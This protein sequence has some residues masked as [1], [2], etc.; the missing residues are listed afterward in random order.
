MSEHG[1][2]DG[3]RHLRG[4]GVADSEADR[5]LPLPELLR[6]AASPPPSKSSS[7]LR[8][9]SSIL[10]PVGL[11]LLAAGGIQLLVR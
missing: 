4:P 2:T 11:I 8:V 9:L 7:G 6:L 5:P 1:Q 10:I 3:I